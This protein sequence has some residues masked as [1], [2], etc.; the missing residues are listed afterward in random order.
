[1]FLFSLS[2]R[3]KDKNAE[4]EPNSTTQ[5]KTIDIIFRFP[6]LKNVIIWIVDIK[7]LNKGTLINTNNTIL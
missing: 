2:N 5:A 3:A 7:E 1:M 6:K 4:I